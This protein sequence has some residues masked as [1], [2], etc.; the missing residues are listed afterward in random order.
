M[1][2]GKAMDDHSFESKIKDKLEHYEYEAG[3]SAQ[4]M[5][6]FVAGLPTPSLPWYAQ[7]AWPYILS[8]AILTS[9][10]FNV[11]FLLKDL[12]SSPIDFHKQEFLSQSP[13]QNYAY[14]DTARV[15]NEKIVT[16]YDTVTVYKEASIMQ[17][18]SLWAN[19]YDTPKT[20]KK[21]PTLLAL[22]PEGA[23]G[24]TDLQSADNLPKAISVIDGLEMGR[25]DWEIEKAEDPYILYKYRKERND[26]VPERKGGLFNGV[27]VALTSGVNLLSA[28]GVNAKASI[29]VGV[30]L[31]KQISNNFSVAVGV[32]YYNLNYEYLPVPLQNRPGNPTS[33]P[34][35]PG[36]LNKIPFLTENF[37]SV[38]ISKSTVL[39]IPLW[40]RWS[41]NKEIAGAIPYAG[42][43]LSAKYT[44]QQSFSVRDNRN[45]P[46]FSNA[47]S[48][49]KLGT[50]N[51]M[52]G[53]RKELSERLSWN[54]QIEYSRDLLP[55][56]FDALQWDM[57]GLQTGLA[58]KL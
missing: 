38:L 43:G 42:V 22:S 1:E 17:P 52:V 9:V 35:P 15:I 29:P 18:K 24:I 11:V 41:F 49:F 25:L 5:A 21:D 4:A 26:V 40:A 3:P 10:V 27:A 53:V 55:N 28:R 46:P 45:T 48:T 51:L 33:R 19:Q 34:K 16:I 14:M 39:E 47:S 37:A 58:L 6:G 23:V 20:S 30:Q 12:G 54:A 13:H 36:K 2:K 7:G 31:Q 8:A 50:L 32:E 56:G 57:I 44:G